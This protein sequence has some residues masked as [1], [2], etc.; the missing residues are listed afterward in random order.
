MRDLE[1]W[2]DQVE[3]SLDG[4]Q[5][6]FLFFGSAVAACVIFVA[7]VFVGKRIE[8]HAV[9]ATQVTA[10]DPLAVLDRLGTSDEDDGLTYHE[11]LIRGDHQGRRMEARAHANRSAAVE[12]AATKA[13][14]KPEAK[15][16]EPS[17]RPAPRESLK[18]ALAEQPAAA[19]T[20]V[21]EPP[22]AQKGDERYTLHLLAFADKSEAEGFLRRLQGSGY[23][24]AMAASEVPG[25]GTF[26]RV[27]VGDFPSRKAALEAKTQ[28]EKKQ[29]I[30]AY[31]SRL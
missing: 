7:G 12:A 4:R 26:Y 25:R 5:I 3:L 18:T 8:Q 17:P 23:K 1:R 14:S 20:A 30:V 16:S 6:F 10:E 27:R 11:A 2:K 24:P 22:T 19:T 29:R 28:F 31:V 9:G 15:P 21:T 13:E